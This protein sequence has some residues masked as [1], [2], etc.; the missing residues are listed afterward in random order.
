MC[1]AQRIKWRMR[2]SVLGTGAA[3]PR[4]GDACAGFLFST[5]ETNVWVDAGNGTFSNL[6][7]HVSY[8]DV[9]ALLLTHGHADH[10][11]DVLPMM[12][13]LGFDPELE[14]TTVPL[15]APPDVAAMISSSLGGSSLAMFKR[16]F[17]AHSIA[18][19]FEIGL[20][21]FSS[22]R[23]VHPIET[24]GLR[25][26]DGSKSVVYT[27]DTAAFPELA[28]HCRDADLLIC[29]ATYVQGAEASP[30]VHLW[31]EEAGK[32]AQDAGAKRLV[33]T[34][35]W[36]TFDLDQAVREASSVYDGPVE[37]ATEGTV[38]EV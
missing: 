14:P 24:Y 18:E 25:V 17:E 32:V 5:G 37:A 21:R 15:Y 26:T 9:D 10:I 38:Y 31:A 7:K 3:Y 28:E 36:P 6:T 16:V 4:A 30:G 2:I 23:T 11:A 13:A 20:L 34:H 12:Y 33:L 19:P 8:R 27:S 29:E 22:F 35:I 1:G